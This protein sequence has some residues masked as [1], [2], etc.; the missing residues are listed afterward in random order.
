MHSLRPLSRDS[1]ELW[2][3]LQTGDPVR[4]VGRKTCLRNAVYQY[5]TPN[6]RSTIIFFV[7]ISYGGRTYKYF[8][9]PEIIIE[10]TIVSPES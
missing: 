9:T 4:V 8:V 1:S 6:S 5:D 3:I 7:D 2:T 10:T